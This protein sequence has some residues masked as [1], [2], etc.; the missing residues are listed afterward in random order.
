MKMQKFKQKDL[1]AMT[2]IQLYRLLEA[3]RRE[4]WKVNK[5]LLKKDKTPKE[6]SY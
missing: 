4:S 6:P 5:T 3:M 2:E 1:N